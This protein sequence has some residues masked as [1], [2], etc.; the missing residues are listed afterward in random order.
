[1]SRISKGGSRF[2][3]YGEGWAR[4]EIKEIPIPRTVQRNGRDAHPGRHSASRTGFWQ[5]RG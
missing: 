1:M 5:E 3:V 2:Q 4:A